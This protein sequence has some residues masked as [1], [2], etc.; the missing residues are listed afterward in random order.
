MAGKARDLRRL[1][2]ATLSQIVRTVDH[3]S[4]DGGSETTSSNQSEQLAAFDYIQSAPLEKLAQI[5]LELRRQTGNSPNDQLLNMA[6]GPN[7]DDKLLFPHLSPLIKA[8]QL[9]FGHRSL[10]NFSQVRSEANYC[11]YV[12][13]LYANGSDPLG[14]V[15][16][17]LNERGS[18]SINNNQFSNNNENILLR[19]TI[20]SASINQT[21]QGARNNNKQDWHRDDLD[22]PN[23]STPTGANRASIYKRSVL[24]TQFNHLHHI[25]LLNM[26][27]NAFN[28]DEDS[29]L[30]NQITGRDVS[31]NTRNMGRTLGSS[32]EGDEEEASVAQ[33]HQQQQGRSILARADTGQ[34]RKRGLLISESDASF[35]T[36]N[37]DDTGVMETGEISKRSLQGFERLPNEDRNQ[38][39]APLGS[40][41]LMIGYIKSNSK[42]GHDFEGASLPYRVGA[43]YKNVS[44]N[45]LEV[46]F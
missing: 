35:T 13:Q 30:E 33:L 3:R 16:S 8:G 43:N 42:S 24:A 19:S 12:D 34:I 18:K 40:I 36:K 11:L 38:L 26:L 45:K 15:G 9:D 23:R 29:S 37:D 20:A 28:R 4:T 7:L 41:D 46:I 22:P 39:L 21:D 27:L 14:L 25:H 1:L 2:D 32:E 31:S 17:E 5:D 10:A 6:F 44:W